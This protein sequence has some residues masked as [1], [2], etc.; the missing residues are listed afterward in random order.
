[1]ATAPNTQRQNTTVGAVCPVSMTSQPTVPE[2]VM[3][4]VISSAPRVMGFMQ[5][6]FVDDWPRCCLRLQ[7]V[8]PND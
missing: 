1:M 5:N 7:S 3:A 6:S 2:M 4:A 8:K